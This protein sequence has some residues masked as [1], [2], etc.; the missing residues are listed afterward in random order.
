MTIHK[1]IR[2]KR[3]GQSDRP[4]LYGL[5]D[6]YLRELHTHREIAAGPADAA[7]Y[8]YLPKYWEE[9]GRHPFFIFDGDACIGFL[10]IREVEAE[11]VIEMSDFYIQSKSR[12]SGVGRAA[13]AEAWRLFPGAWSLQVHPLNKAAS[14]F[15]PRMIAAFSHGPIDSYEVTEEDGH[16]REFRFGIAAE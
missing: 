15:W 2:L 5:V 7:S 8:V 10:L 14:I 1:E 12:R 11:G 9:P 13:L 6:D 16:R 3:V 4:A